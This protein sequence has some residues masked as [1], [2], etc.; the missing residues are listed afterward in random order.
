MEITID[1]PRLFEPK[2]GENGKLLKTGKTYAL[3][4]LFTSPYLHHL[5]ISR[6]AAFLSYAFEGR[7]ISKAAE[8]IRVSPKT[9]RRWLKKAEGHLDKLLLEIA[10]EIFNHRSSI[11]DFLRGIGSDR[12]SK[13][14]GLFISAYIWV[15]RILRL[16][17]LYVDPSQ[18]GLTGIINLFLQESGIGGF[19]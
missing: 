4:P 8:L 11:P 17:E 15:F 19:I 10:K 14:R 1:I 13:L 3:Y 7:G 6:D 16:D 12:R 2:I 9:F 18:I 5:N